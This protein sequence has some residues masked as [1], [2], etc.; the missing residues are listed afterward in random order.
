MEAGTPRC[1]IATDTNLRNCA[2][3]TYRQNVRILCKRRLLLSLS[4]T[5]EHILQLDDYF[6]CLCEEGERVHIMGGWNLQ[7]NKRNAFRLLKLQSCVNYVILNLTCQF[8]YAR[9]RTHA[10][11]YANSPSVRPSHPVCFKQR[12]AEN[13]EIFR[14]CWYMRMRTCNLNPKKK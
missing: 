14:W 7:P 4:L 10:Y 3:H 2:P 5:V 9:T 1:L 6:F 13:Y 12:V 11:T 8:R